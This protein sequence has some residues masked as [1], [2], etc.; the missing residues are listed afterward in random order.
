MQ[1]LDD[2]GIPYDDIFFGKPWADV[3]VDD[4]A[5]HANMDTRRE[6]GWMASDDGEGS[7]PSSPQD[8][9]PPRNFNHVQVIGDRFVKSSKS[10]A[11][12][13]EMFFY[14]RIPDS[15]RELFPTVH[16]LGYEQ[17]TSS[18]SITMDKIK[19][20][21]FSH[22]LV[23]RSLTPGR[24]AAF[25]D[26]LHRIHTS[27]PESS[28]LLPTPPYIQSRFDTSSATPSTSTAPIY[29][30]YAQKLRSR[31]QTHS[32]IYAALNSPSTSTLYHTL[33]TRLS[34]YESHSR[35]RP[36]A[37]IHGDPVFS[38][39]ILDDLSSR[40]R[41]YDVRG[42]QGDHFTLEGDICYDLAKV[43]QSLQGYDHALLS[44]PEESEGASADRGSNRIITPRFT[45]EPE[46]GAPTSAPAAAAA[47]AAV[48]SAGT[49]SPT[50]AAEE[51]KTSQGPGSF[52]LDRTDRKI[53][54]DLQTQFWDFVDRKYNRN[55]HGSTTNGKDVEP[56]RREDIL[57][58]TASLLFS[59]IPL[60]RPEMRP[61]FLGMCERVLRNGCAFA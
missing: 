19:G 7:N 57:T 14:S 2:Y 16:S 6:I 12:L 52:Y 9:I 28:N 40:V 21:T 22:L 44:N 36:T 23:G 39:A 13:G 47:A 54:L 50:T 55:T 51:E 1:S 26:S 61:V 32:D 35:A 48:T 10:D 42:L 34:D 31:W 25:L 24:F 43:F 3:Y 60:H 18:Y 20:I 11:I 33:L 46:G 53:L 49:V 45:P 29:S 27:S 30:N 4:L 38:N 58:I 5:V 56:I 15:L 17:E 37:V 8:V 59:L 41:F